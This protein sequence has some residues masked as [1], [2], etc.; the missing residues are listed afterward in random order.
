[1]RLRKLVADD[2]VNVSPGLVFG[3][4]GRIGGD[5]NSMYLFE[6]IAEGKFKCGKMG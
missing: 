2:W 4:W 1:M 6:G 5:C 3:G